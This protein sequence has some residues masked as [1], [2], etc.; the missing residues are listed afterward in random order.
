MAEAPAEPRLIA[1]A[2]IARPHGVRGELRLKLYNRDSELLLHLDQVV[3]EHADKARD[4]VDIVEAR[5]ANDAILMRLEG[6]DDRDQAEG[7]RGARLLVPRDLFPPV[8]EGEFYVCDVVGA[9]VVAP[10]GEVGVVDDIL[11]Y[12]TCDALRVKTAEGYLELPLVDGVVDEVDTQ[13][14]VV[15]VSRRDPLAED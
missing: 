12:P 7:L 4:L 13:A 2:E 6:C 9:R 11:S 3:L 8:E 15:R 10:D 1:L 5:K 14:G